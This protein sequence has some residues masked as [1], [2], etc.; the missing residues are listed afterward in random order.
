MVIIKT[1]SYSAQTSR[2]TVEVPGFNLPLILLYPKTLLQ[3]KGKQYCF[4]LTFI[5]LLYLY[6]ARQMSE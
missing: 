4:P 5:E 2:R 3:Q 6:T 1:K